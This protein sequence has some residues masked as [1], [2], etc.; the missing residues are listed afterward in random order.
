MFTSFIF[1]DMSDESKNHLHFYQT[2][3]KKVKMGG[4]KKFLILSMWSGVTSWRKSDKSFNKKEI[5]R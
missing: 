1:N 3:F 2:I 4:S 5:F